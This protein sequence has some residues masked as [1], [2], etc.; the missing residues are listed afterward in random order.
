ME[1]FLC[2]SLPGPLFRLQQVKVRAVQILE[3]YIQIKAGLLP[4]MAQAGKFKSF[5]SWSWVFS[6]F[7]VI[8]YELKLRKNLACDRF[9]LFLPPALAL[10]IFSVC[11]TCLLRTN[12]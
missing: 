12:H 10:S 3:A 8:T 1:Y 11:V 2:V 7:Y 5:S 9:N 4:E 6:G